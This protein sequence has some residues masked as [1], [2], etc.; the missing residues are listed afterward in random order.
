MALETFTPFM[1]ISLRFLI[2]G[3]LLLAGAKILG[4]AFPRGAEL[5][6]IA[7]N[8]LLL[9]GVG[10]GCLAF[11]E[12]WIPSGLAALIV[13]ISPFWLVGFEAAV[14]G[15]ASLHFPTVMG[16]LIGLFGVATLVAPG[17]VDLGHQSNLIQAFLV[18]QLGCIGWSLGSILLKRQESKI[19]PIVAGAVQQFTV[20]VVTLIPALVIPHPA[21]HWNPRGIGALL[22]LVTFGSIV[23]YSAYLYALSH[24]PVAVVSIYNY[25]TPLVAVF[26]GWLIYREQFGMRE[27]FAMAVIFVGVAVVKTTSAKRVI[28]R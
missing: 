14:P 24:L 8:G 5:R 11:A 18:L 23:G 10:N 13:T 16:M 19:H 28:S 22:Y 1:L 2:S 4:A 21:I 15:G 12:Q 25:V 7:L 27:A 3:S 9:L 17:G 20:G 26:L 6:R